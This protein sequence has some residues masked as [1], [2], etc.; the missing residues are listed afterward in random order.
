VV[1]KE[2]METVDGGS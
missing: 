1:D 2:S